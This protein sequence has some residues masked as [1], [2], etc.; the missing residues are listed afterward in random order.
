MPTLQFKGKPFVQNHHLAVKYHQLVPNEKNSLT[1]PALGGTGAISLHDN[2]II[3]GDNLKAL[4]ALLPTYGGKVKCIYIDPPYN[5]GNEGWV[6][7]DNVNSPMMQEWLGK[8]VD[9]EDMTRHDKWLC[10]MMPRLKLLRELL[11]EDGAIFISCD[12]NEQHNLRCMLDEVFGEQNFVSNIIWQK[13]YAASNDAKYFSDNHDFII[14]YAKNKNQGDVK[15]GWSRKL[16]PRTEKQNKLYKYDS[17]DG[18]GLWRPDNLTVKSYSPDY[19]YPII[20]PNTKVEYNPTKGRC[21]LTNK[22]KMADWIKSERVFF[23]QDGKGAPQL[24]RYL[25]EV[26]QGTV[27][28]TIWLYDD[29]N[30]TDGARKELKDIFSESSSPFQTPKPTRLISQILRLFEKDSI[31]LDSFAGSGT[32]AHAVLDL[33]KEDGGNRK[34]ILV[35]MEDYANTITA[36]RARRVIKGV[37]ESKNF[38]EGAGGSFSYFELGKP[39]EMNHILDGTNLPSYVEFAR[40]LFYTA[41]GEQFEESKIN[42]QTG[43]IGESSHYEVYLIYKPDIEYLKSTALTLERAKA[44]PEFKGKQRLVFAPMKYLDQ[45]FLRDLRIDFCQLPYEVYK[46]EK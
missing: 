30:H 20:N 15:N 40:Y 1:D 17:N 23:G 18:N 45:H 25:N 12:D 36:E 37:P 44:L 16:L 46:M 4:K 2:L 29:V 9:T 42:E 6:Y 38:K 11:A 8:E 22:E 31:I 43:F 24:K 14:C 32:T 3:Q 39:I 28:L 10:M 27:P 19:D 5:T 34:F 7:N 41:T 33:N 26:Q 35:E 21:W 13:K